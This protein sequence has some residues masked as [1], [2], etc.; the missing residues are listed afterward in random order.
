VIQPANGT[1]IICACLPRAT[2]TAANKASPNPTAGGNGCY[3]EFKAPLPV[4]SKS[5]NAWGLYDLASCW[6]E[7]MADRGMYNVRHAEVDPRYPPGA[8]DPGKVQRSG[9]GIIKDNWSISTHEF[10][11]EKGYA[12]RKFR[13]VVVTP[14]DKTK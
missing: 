11:A 2:W 12:G 8:A 1:V 4:K 7:I 14:T 9:R 13:V 6:W 3:Y 5:P 10:I